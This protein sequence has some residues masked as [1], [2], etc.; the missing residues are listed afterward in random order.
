MKNV[1][2]VPGF[3]ASPDSHWF[4]WLAQQVQQRDVD[5]NVIQ[6]SNAFA[7][8]FEVWQSDLNRQIKGLSPDT[9]IIAHDLGCLSVLHYLSEQL[10]GRKI[11][12]IILVAGFHEKVVSLP[13]FNGFIQKSKLEDGVLRTHIQQRYV[14]FS[15][16]DAIIPAPQSIHFGQRLNAQMIE[17][18]Q[19]GHFT[20]ADG[21]T[22][23]HPLWEILAPMLD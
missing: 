8:D 10:I 4:R 15:S 6:W 12:A 13:E 20:Q 5:C 23:F 19:A 1:F 22:A 17:I 11:K 18:K 21:F 9:I 3:K 2:I 16:H 7:A 14:L